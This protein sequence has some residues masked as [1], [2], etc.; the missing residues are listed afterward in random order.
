MSFDPTHKD[1]KNFFIS[2]GGFRPK[3]DVIFYMAL[4]AEWFERNG[5]NVV[6]SYQIATTSSTRSNN[7]IMYMRPGKRLSLPEI[8]ELGIRSVCTAEDALEQLLKKKVQVILIS[9]NIT[10]EWS[11]L[12]D[13]DESYITR[14]LALVRKSPITDG[15]NIKIT[16]KPR[17]PVGVKE[18]EAFLKRM[19]G[20]KS[21]ELICLT[22]IRSIISSSVAVIMVVGMKAILS[23]EPVIILTLKT[24]YGL[25]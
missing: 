2:G 23:E 10:A 15:N 3:F 20:S 4:D 22:T 11:V 21:I 14:R 7:I 13:R 12:A 5:R 25:I 24:S 6:L 18:W 16:I 1:Y 8:V 19:N 17:L 9:H